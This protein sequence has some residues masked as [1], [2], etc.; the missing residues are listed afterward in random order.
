MKGEERIIELLSEYLRKS[1]KHEEEIRQNQQNIE[2]VLIKLD[3]NQV[4]IENNQKEIEA[5][6]SESLKRQVQQDVLLQEILSISKR[7]STLES[8]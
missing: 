6:R 5:L 8:N 7:V 2:K 1:D 4:S 3:Q